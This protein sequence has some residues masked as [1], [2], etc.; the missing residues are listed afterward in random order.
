MN[1]QDL[2]GKLVKVTVPVK[3]VEYSMN[4]KVIKAN[5]RSI[6]FMEVVKTERKNIFRKAKIKLVDSFTETHIVFKESTKFDKWESSWDSIA[7]LPSYAGKTFSRHSRGWAPSL[8]STTNSYVG[9][10]MV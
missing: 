9:F 2:T 1:I 10:P 3:G 8:P 5:T 4:L 7:T 6:L